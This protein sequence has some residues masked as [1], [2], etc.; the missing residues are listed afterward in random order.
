MG[1]RESEERSGG[2]SAECRGYELR[3]RNGEKVGKVDEV[4]VDEN[5]RPEYLGVKT[6]L[7]G[8]KLSLIP[9]T[10]ARADEERRR[11]ELSESR[12][13]LKDAPS[14][15]ANEEITA[16]REREVREHFGL[17]SSGGEQSTPSTGY[18]EDLGDSS[19]SG[20]EPAGERR[21]G[22]SGSEEQREEREP[23]SA[24]GSEAGQGSRGESS[25]EGSTAA[26]S[27]SSE[28]SR[29]R[30]GTGGQPEES[31]GRETMRVSVWREKARAE[32]VVGDD[33]SEEV[34]IRKQWV[35]EEEIVEVEEGNR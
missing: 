26:G 12:D 18:R 22:S 33:G 20:E 2:L 17:G 19:S 10:L 34:R 3:D 27:A 5:D 30:R 35:E 21:S 8:G 11:I 13:R 9:A 29:E 7:L 1:Y 4:F 28:E 15:G 32:R 31:S 25:S 14:L 24:A 16:E 23:W 6:G